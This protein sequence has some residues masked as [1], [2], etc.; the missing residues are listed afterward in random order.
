MGTIPNMAG[1]CQQG[2]MEMNRICVCD[3]NELF[4]IIN[5]CP[6]LRTVSLVCTFGS[7]CVCVKECIYISKSNVQIDYKQFEVR[8]KFKIICWTEKVKIKKNVLYY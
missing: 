3:G 8:K 1:I 7:V 4:G 5:L 6:Y 2:I